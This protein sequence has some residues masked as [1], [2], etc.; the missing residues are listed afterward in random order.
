MRKSMTWAAVGTTAAAAAL[1][2][3]AAG[4]ANAATLKGTSLSIEKS[5]RSITAGQTVTISGQ[6]KSGS[7]AVDHRAVTL[8]WVGAHGVPHPI[9][10]GTTSGP[11][12]NVSFELRPGA[13]TT[14]ELAFKSSDGYAG[15]YSGKVTVP[16][17]KI[18]TTLGLAASA[19]SVEV[20]T[21]VT[22]TG[23]LTA[24]KTDVNG[25]SVALD[26]VDS[27]GH[28]HSTHRTQ[29]TRA[30]VV[31]FTV[32]PGSTTTY[33]LVYAGNWQY[34]GSNSKPAKVTV[35]KVPTTL[36]A[37]EA[38]GATAG[39]ETITGTLKTESGTALGGETVTLKYKDAKGDWL[40][41][42]SSPTKAGTVVFTV[43][44]ATARTY[45][46]VFTGTPVYS[47]ATSNTVIAG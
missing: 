34:K 3:V 1:S 12:G 27:K 16:V 15:S 38:T 14:Y 13:T 47:A 30:G 33:E 28:L 5:A 19:T 35:T 46:L 29:N 39:H 11:A 17:Y 22:L 10:R 8:D 20:G 45:E 44:P 4:T 40:S 26:T 32:E 18:G 42:G 41:L 24:G 9:T 25:Q 21:K 36:V 6:L 2:S 31:S 37:V 23:T 43:A 7:T